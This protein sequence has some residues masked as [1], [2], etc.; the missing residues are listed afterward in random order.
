MTILWIFVCGFAPLAHLCTLDFVVLLM[1]NKMIAQINGYCFVCNR[2]FTGHTG[3]VLG[4]AVSP[5]DDLFLST[6]LDR[7]VGS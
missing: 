5:K 3:R 7:E 2:Y 1:H 4:L 6:G